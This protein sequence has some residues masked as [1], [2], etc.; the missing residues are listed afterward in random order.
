MFNIPQTISNYN[1]Y[2]TLNKTVYTF[3][4]NQFKFKHP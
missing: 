1:V 3:Y 4:T 2:V